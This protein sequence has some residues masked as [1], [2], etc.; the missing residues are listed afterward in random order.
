MNW[1]RIWNKE[2]LLDANESLVQALI[3][4]DGF[5]S[6]AGK[7]LEKDWLAYIERVVGWLRIGS[8]ESLYEVGCGDGALLY[9]LY[10]RGVKVGGMDYALPLVNIAR[11]IMPEACIDHG[12][13]AALQK[14]PSF[15]HVLSQSVFHYFPDLDY[16]RTV[17]KI[18][19]AKAHKSVA[20]LEIPDLARKEESEAERSRAY[21]PG[22]YEKKYLG[23]G[24]L[25]YARDWFMEEATGLGHVAE[26]FDQR[27]ITPNANSGSMS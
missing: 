10:A 20:V 2:K 14:E 26:T 15:D 22:E 5:E 19:L 11:Q 25:Y 18:M 17:L 8:G 23:L 27:T 12:E 1:E 16:A 24:H 21:P 9:P 4:A 13:A 3:F 7:I 6:G